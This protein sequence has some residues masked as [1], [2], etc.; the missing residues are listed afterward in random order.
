M[1]RPVENPSVRRRVAILDPTMHGPRYGNERPDHPT[2]VGALT[3][4]RG[5][6]SVPPHIEATR[7]MT[8]PTPCPAMELANKIEATLGTVADL[9]HS[10]GHQDVTEHDTL[11]GSS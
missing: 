6:P 11:W 3:R 5:P 1:I 7:T 9:R 2:M 10:V 4:M 8:L